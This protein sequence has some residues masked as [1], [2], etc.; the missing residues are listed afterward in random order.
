[1]SSRG[2]SVDGTDWAGSTFTNNKP[3]HTFRILYQNINSLGTS[4]YHHNIQE[5]AVTQQELQVDL[6][7]FTEHCLNVT[8]PRILNSIRQS[9]NRQFLGQYVIQM[10]SAQVTR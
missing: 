6:A 4:Q 9:L 8:Q 7:G 3:E 2:T 10:N 1:M 5:L